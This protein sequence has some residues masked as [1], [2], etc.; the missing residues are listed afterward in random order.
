MHAVSRCHLIL[1]FMVSTSTYSYS[2]TLP[3]VV[4]WPGVLEALVVYGVRDTRDSGMACS[5]CI[6]KNTTRK[7]TKLWDGGPDWL[8]IESRDWTWMQACMHAC[9]H[10][11]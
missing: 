5:V 1:F 8:S 6:V 9:M 3:S 4:L 2:T 7:E 11:D 10:E